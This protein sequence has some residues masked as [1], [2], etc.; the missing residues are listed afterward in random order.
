[1]VNNPTSSNA[2]LNKAVEYAQATQLFNW[3]PSSE[4]VSQ[5]VAA[6]FAK[7]PGW[8]DA[9]IKRD[10]VFDGRPKEQNYIELM[11]YQGLHAIAF[12]QQAH[13]H[14]EAAQ[15]LKSSGKRDEAAA[16]LMRA[17]KISQGV[18]RLTAGIEIH[19][20]ATIG[21]NFFIDHGAGVVIGETAIIGNDVF[22]YHNITLGA[23]SG[24]TVKE[25]NGVE[26]RHPKVGN[27]VIISTGSKVLGPATIE[28]DVKIGSNVLVKGNVTI[29]KGATIQDGLTITHDVPAGARVIG[30][31][32]S[33]PGL[34]DRDE[35]GT[36]IMVDTKNPKTVIGDGLAHLGKGIQNL[37]S[38]IQQ[39]GRAGA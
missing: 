2:A 24:K 27:R 21:K 17:R 12:H 35:G 7:E 30:T 25:A 16:E 11:T 20:G 1:M 10:P 4:D 6:F 3:T 37:L 31:V 33:L 14:Y 8:A 32:P 26:R 39:S 28:D 5:A 38:S 18:R 19:P 22:L 23:A 13:A 36:P 15:K 9:A 34:L 29:G